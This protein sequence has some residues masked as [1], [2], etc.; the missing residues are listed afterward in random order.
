MSADDSDERETAET[1]LSLML[2][3]WSPREMRRAWL[4]GVVM[5]AAVGLVL[6]FVF[7][8]YAA[9]GDLPGATAAIALALPLVWTGMF[10]L[11]WRDQR[12]KRSQHSA[13]D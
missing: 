2:G 4:L 11:V 12:R 1:S 7:G 8:P 13:S 10:G 9:G 6:G 5:M 3:S